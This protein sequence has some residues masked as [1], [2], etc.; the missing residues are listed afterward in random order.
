MVYSAAWLVE[1]IGLPKPV[2]TKFH[3]E[4]L[5]TD[6][7]YI[8]TSMEAS[9]LSE[10]IE[11]VIEDSGQHTAGRMLICPVKLNEMCSFQLL[12]SDRLS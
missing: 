5:T 4:Y 6:R 8:G 11:Q 9:T 10:V 2:P 7:K 12:S 3:V 1:K